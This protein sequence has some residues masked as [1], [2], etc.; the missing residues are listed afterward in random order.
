[1]DYRLVKIEELS[2]EE[3]SVYSI[4][5]ENEQVTAYEKFIQE[6]ITSFK[7]EIIDIN[8]RLQIIGNE[9]GARH[10]FFKHKEGSPGDGVCALYDDPDKKLRLYCVRYGTVMVVLGG[11]GPKPKN[12][13]ALQEDPK[14][15]EENNFVRQVS[16]DIR[17]R[18]EEGEIRFINYGLEFEGD[19]EFKTDDYE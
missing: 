11:G 12:I 2:G 10:S 1:M 5:M 19:L 13:Q 17:T 7:S 18:M 6:N 16:N 14:L 8:K 9:T 3:A 15:T 4:Y